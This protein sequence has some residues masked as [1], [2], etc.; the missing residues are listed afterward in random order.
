[1]ATEMANLESKLQGT[2]WDNNVR[3]SYSISIPLPHRTAWFFYS[4]RPSRTEVL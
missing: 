3:R 2:V 4:V 1:V